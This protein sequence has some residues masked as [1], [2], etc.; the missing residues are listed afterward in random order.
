MYYR[1]ISLI[2]LLTTI[3][4]LGCNDTNQTEKPA[5]KHNFIILADLSDRIL[6]ENQV[7]ND[8]EIIKYI[9]KAFKDTVRLKFFIQSTDHIKFRIAGLNK[10]SYGAD[11]EKQL[12]L[13]LEKM[14]I[15]KKSVSVKNLDKSLDSILT[16]LYDR[17]V[18]SNR[19]AKITESN[20]WKYF[21]DELE[22]DLVNDSLTI[23]YLFILTD[24]YFRALNADQAVQTNNRFSSIDFIALLRGNDWETKLT[25]YDYGIIP[26]RKDL[27]NTRVMLSELNPKD[28]F[29]YE[30][31][32]LR[33][34]WIKWFSEMKISS[35]KVSKRSSTDKTKDEI[36]DF[37]QNKNMIAVVPDDWGTIP[38]PDTVRVGFI[39]SIDPKVDPETNN[40]EINER[41][42]QTAQNDQE[43]K[44]QEVKENTLP[45]V[46]IPQNNENNKIKEESRP[47]Q[48]PYVGTIRLDNGNIYTGEILNGKPHGWGKLTYQQAGRISENSPKTAEALD[49]FVG[50]WA[51]GDPEIG[52]LYDKN[53][54]HKNTLIF[55]S[56][57]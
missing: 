34:I 16:V 54:N 1:I 9:Y 52:D 43:K 48:Q 56:S 8:K 45:P 36:S 49:Y 27:G 10:S 15:N 24:G 7:Q 19:E 4:L 32:L 23:N 28:G 42:E 29:L 31:D 2:A 18:Q 47:I 26:V 13:N 53:G 38:T 39:P 11:F 3:I 22:S 21:N 35:V 37:L 50:K 44:G 12:S 5:T 33:Q 30:Y 25:E 20:I 41:K 6:D 40:Q 51:K 17:A 14:E 46:K 55:G 57:D